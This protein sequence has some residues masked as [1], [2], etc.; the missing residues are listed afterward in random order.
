MPRRLLG[1]IGPFPAASWSRRLRTPRSWFPGVFAPL[2]GKF[3]HA[4]ESSGWRRPHTPPPRGANRLSALSMDASARTVAT[5]C[6]RAFIELKIASTR[7]SPRSRINF[8]AASAF[9][10]DANSS[11][12]RT[13]SEDAGGVSPITIERGE[14][15]PPSS[16]FSRAINDRTCASASAYSRCASA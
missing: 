5:G 12:D 11:P 4:A 15:A 13:L 16:R 8:S 1:R 14:D 3:F 10:S 2:R 6:P 7:R 9:V